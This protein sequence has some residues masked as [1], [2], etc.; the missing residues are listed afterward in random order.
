[1]TNTR[2]VSY[3]NAEGHVDKELAE[4]SK[5]SNDAKTFES[6]FSIVLSFGEDEGPIE[7]RKLSLTDAR[8]MVVDILMALAEFGD[9]VAR[10]IG[11]NYFAPD[12]N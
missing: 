9:P 4:K 7:D 1:M 2:N 10:S 6:A 11:E 12:S 8:D 3:I 5:N